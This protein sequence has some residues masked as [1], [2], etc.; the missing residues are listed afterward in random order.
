MSRSRKRPI[1]K[2]K[3]RFKSIYWKVI[4]REWKQ[5]LNNNYYHEDFELRNPKSIINDYD[6]S[7]Y[8]FNVI[9]WDSYRTYEDWLYW[10]NKLSRK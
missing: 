4:R 2:D 3:A 10:K 8:S 1:Y 5:S 7:D 6:Y 9:N